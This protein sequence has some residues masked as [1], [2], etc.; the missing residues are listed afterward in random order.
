MKAPSEKIVEVAKKAM[1]N[2]N[3]KDEFMDVALD[4]FLAVN[5]KGTSKDITQ[6]TIDSLF[7]MFLAG[8]EQ[9]LNP[10]S[11]FNESWNVIQQMNRFKEAKAKLR[12]KK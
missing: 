4:A 8:I 11:R 10:K 5:D 7:L 2:A 6:S 12:E 1:K 3:F 9:V